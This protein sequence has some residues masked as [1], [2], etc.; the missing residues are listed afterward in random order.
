MHPQERIDN[1]SIF[2][3]CHT[4][5]TRR[6]VQRADIRSDELLKLGVGLLGKVVFEIWVSISRGVD[7]GGQRL[8]LDGG[9]NETEAADEGFKVVFVLEIAWSIISYNIKMMMRRRA[10]CGSIIGESAGL[11]DFNLIVPELFGLDPG[12]NEKE[13]VLGT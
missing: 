8:L 10:Y 9:V 11:L 1:S 6:V 12:V 4:C 5:R 13:L 2:E 7:T 3:G